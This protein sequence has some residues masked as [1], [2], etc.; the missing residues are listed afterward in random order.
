MPVN[1][2]LDDLI[3]KL[4]DE[5]VSA[6]E[7]FQQEF[8]ETAIPESIQSALVPE[9]ERFTTAIKKMPPD[10][11][12][13][14]SKEIESLCK[15]YY[16]LKAPS[17][18]EQKAR[19]VREFIEVNRKYGIA[20]PPVLLL[21]LNIGSFIF[22]LLRFILELRR[23]RQQPVQKKPVI[24]DEVEKRYES[25]PVPPH[26]EYHE[27]EPQT[28]DDRPEQVFG[29]IVFEGWLSDKF[30]NIFKEKV[31]PVVL[32]GAVEFLEQKRELLLDVLVSSIKSGLETALNRLVTSLKNRKQEFLL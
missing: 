14:Y 21:L 20:I 7:E 25:E 31:L 27:L 5:S 24:G 30:K 29:N 9:S 3:N 13:T 22:S 18:R 12:E 28:P 11:F 17:R 32:D 26:D 19:L 8:G 2:S 10:Q 6:E 16:G 23:R 15:W 1:L 4:N